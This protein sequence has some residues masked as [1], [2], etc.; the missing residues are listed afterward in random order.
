M[1]ARPFDENSGFSLKQQLAAQRAAL[2]T[3]IQSGHLLFD[4]R[5][6]FLLKNDEWSLRE[7]VLL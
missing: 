4:G 3:F 7:G 6:S 2:Y 1:N 5:F